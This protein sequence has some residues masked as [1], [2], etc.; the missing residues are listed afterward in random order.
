MARKRFARVADCAPARRSSL[1]A[2][3][4]GNA[5]AMLPAPRS[6]ALRF[7]RKGDMIWMAS[8]CRRP[9]P[10]RVGLGQLQEQLLD[11]VVGRLERRLD[12]LARAFVGRVEHSPV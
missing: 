10:E 8:L 4:H 9:I 6:T 2:S 3:S 11:V 12:G 5:M 1:M 7:S